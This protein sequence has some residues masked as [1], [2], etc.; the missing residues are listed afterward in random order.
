[1]LHDDLDVLVSEP[2]LSKPF[3]PLNDFCYIYQIIHGL[4]KRR[5]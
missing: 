5:N 3:N 4:I 2:S 1:M